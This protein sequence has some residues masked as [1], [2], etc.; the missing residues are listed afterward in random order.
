MKLKGKNKEEKQTCIQNKEKDEKMMNKIC[1]R[2]GTKPAD[3]QDIGLLSFKIRWKMS[4]DFCKTFD[5]IDFR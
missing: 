2:V 5:A 4:R 1:Q 3:L